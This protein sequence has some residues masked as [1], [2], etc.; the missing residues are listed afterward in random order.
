[1]TLCF[2]CCPDN[3]SLYFTDDPGY[4]DVCNC[5]HDKIQGVK[6]PPSYV[7]SLW[8]VVSSIVYTSV[9]NRVIILALFTVWPFLNFSAV[10]LISLTHS[11][12]EKKGESFIIG[13]W[14]VLLASTWSHLYLRGHIWVSKIFRNCQCLYDWRVRAFKLRHQVQGNLWKL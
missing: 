9:E 7:E 5:I 2:S 13:K 3:L 11:T 1:M 10:G 6:M 8:N 4:C 12:D 14:C